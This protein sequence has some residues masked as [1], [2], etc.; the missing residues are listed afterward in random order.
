M[1]SVLN[2]CK[3]ITWF[4]APQTPVHSNCVHKLYFVLT[5]VLGFLKTNPNYVLHKYCV[6]IYIY[7]RHS[8]DLFFILENRYIFGTL[9]FEANS[10]IDIYFC[11]HPS[12]IRELI[13]INGIIN[14][15]KHNSIHPARTFTFQFQKAIN[16][17]YRKWRPTYTNLSFGTLLYYTVAVWFYCSLWRLCYVYCS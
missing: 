11:L 9:I 3:Y 8:N 6:Y 15:T 7:I 5:C 14:Y 17:D 13:T 12:I 2:T 1:D 10:R 4:Y 16:R